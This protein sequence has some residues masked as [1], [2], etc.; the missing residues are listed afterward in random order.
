MKTLSL[1]VGLYWLFIP[2]SSAQSRVSI[3]PTYWFA[4]NPYSYQLD[5]TYN[6]VPTQIQ[7]SGYNTISSFGLTAHYRLGSQWDLSVG[8]L[9]QRSTDHMKTPQSPYGE[10]ATFT[11]KGVQ[12]PVLLSYRLTDHRLSPYF[13]AGALFIKSITFTNALVKTE[14]LVGAG[15]DYRFR[16]GLSLLVQP[17]AS[18]GIF[19]PVRAAFP[20]YENYRSYSLG[21]QTQLILHF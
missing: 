5:M 2:L 9:Y 15:L 11:T 16:S 6:A 3:A 12:V 14:G 8:A 10:S 21:V 4:Y 7:A 17:T 13:S 19:Q 20:D 18:Y 1:I